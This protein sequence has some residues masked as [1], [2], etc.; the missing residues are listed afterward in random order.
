[1]CALLGSQSTNISYAT[2]HK[3]LRLS[4]LEPEIGGNLYFGRKITAMRRKLPFV[5][6]F[7]I[8]LAI[9]WLIMMALP[10]TDSNSSNNTP[11][12]QP[13]ITPIHRTPSATPTEALGIILIS[14][15]SQS[16]PTFVVIGRGKA[17]RHTPYSTAATAALICPTWAIRGPGRPQGSPLPYDEAACQAR[18]W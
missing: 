12:P 16:A 10:L 8:C 11:Q 15:R 2:F 7:L 13:S 17:R 6:G 5:I 1:M 18:I 3:F 4:L 9:S 14:S